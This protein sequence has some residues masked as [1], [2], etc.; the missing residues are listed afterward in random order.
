MLI[1]CVDAPCGSRRICGVGIEST[2]AVMCTASDAAGLAAGPDELRGT[3]G[4]QASALG[5]RIAINGLSRHRLT[6]L[7]LSSLL[8]HLGPR[9]ARRPASSD[10]TP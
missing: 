4:N 2:G 8:Q 5:W 6:G 1:A 9:R 3:R 7:S 10:A